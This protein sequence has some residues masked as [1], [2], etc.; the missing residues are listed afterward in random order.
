MGTSGAE[1]ATHS[2]FVRKEHQ[3]WQK[4]VH[5]RGNIEKVLKACKVLKFRCSLRHHEY[6]SSHT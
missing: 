4:L 1:L 5:E 3:R 6:E 2:A